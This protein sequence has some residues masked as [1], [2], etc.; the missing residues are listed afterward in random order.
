M[1]DPGRMSATSVVHI[2][3]G[4]RLRYLTSVMLHP[5]RRRQDPGT[6]RRLLAFLDRVLVRLAFP[7]GFWAR[8]VVWARRRSYQS[9]RSKMDRPPRAELSPYNF[10]SR[11]GASSLMAAPLLRNHPLVYAGGTDHAPSPGLTETASPITMPNCW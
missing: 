1:I 4:T 11:V 7:S 2:V 6:G 10:R 9:I 5:H 8:G 3:V